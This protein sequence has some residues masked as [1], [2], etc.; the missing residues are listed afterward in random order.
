MEQIAAALREE[1]ENTA[2]Q[3]I[4]PEILPGQSVCRAAVP[5]VR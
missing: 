2:V 3:I 5:A 1:P 4:K